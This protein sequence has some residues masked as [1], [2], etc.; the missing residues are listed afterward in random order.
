VEDHVAY[1]ATWQGRA[2]PTPPS[3]WETKKDKV[4][5]ANRARQLEATQWKVSS[6]RSLRDEVSEGLD[7]VAMRVYL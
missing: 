7:K 2:K 6:A 3:D 5:F 1:S 4:T